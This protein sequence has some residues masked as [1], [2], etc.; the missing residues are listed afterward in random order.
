MVKKFII[1]LAIVLSVVSFVEPVDAHTLK[2]DGPIGAVIHISPEDDPIVGEQSDFFFEIKDKEN[3]FQL[4]KCHC[5]ALVVKDERVIYS[6]TFSQHNGDPSLTS[7][8]FGYTFPEKGIYKIM[9][10]GMPIESFTFDSFSLVYEIRVSRESDKQNLPVQTSNVSDFTQQSILHY[11]ILSVI[12]AV[13]IIIVFWNKFRG[14]KSKKNAKTLT[15]IIVFILI[16]SVTLLNLCFQSQILIENDTHTKH[17]EAQ[18]SSHSD[19][20][21]HPCCTTQTASPLIA[22]DISP[23][24]ELFSQFRQARLTTYYYKNSETIKNKSPPHSLS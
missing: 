3:K 15:S 12:A 21:V 9:V 7:S 4:S 18:N 16:S 22:L 23:Q 19:H 11:V 5:E 24:L 6:T 14:D 8:S 10:N 2:T 1:I 20:Q 17:A 13:F